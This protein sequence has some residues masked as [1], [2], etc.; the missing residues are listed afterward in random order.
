VRSGARF[1]IAVALAVVL[2]GWLAYVSLGGT[3]QRFASPG[4]LTAGGGTYRLT[5]LVAGGAPGDAAGRAQSASGL[6]FRVQDKKDPAR[7]V[8]VIYRGSVPD[9]FRS[10]REIVL[11]GQVSDGLF[12][13]ERNSLITLCPS[14]FQAK[15]SSG[16]NASPEGGA[17]SPASS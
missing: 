4:E 5:G 2:G 14:K 7:S 8:M 12:V 3:L 11:T 16:S 1:F 9:T 6:R 17:G 15:P 10:G 13:A